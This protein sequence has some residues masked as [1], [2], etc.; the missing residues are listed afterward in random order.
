MSSRQPIKPAV[1]EAPDKPSGGAGD[2]G[3]SQHQGRELQ[4]VN[5]RLVEESELLRLALAETDSLRQ[6]EATVLRERTILFDSLKVLSNARSSSDALHALLASLGAIYQACPVCLLVTIDNETRVYASADENHLDLSVPLVS[7]AL[8]QSRRMASLQPLG[9]SATLPEVFQCLHSLVMVPLPLESVSQQCALLLGAR[10]SGHFS[11]SDLRVVER[12][13]ALAQPILTGLHEAEERERLQ[14]EL[15]IAQR[16]EMIGQVAAGLAHDFNNLLAAIGGNASLISS[17]VQ[18]GSAAATGAGRIQAAVDQAGGLVRRLLA[19]GARQP[20]R[21]LIDLGVPVRQAADLLQANLHPPL[22]LDVRLSDDTLKVL[23]DPTDIMQ[24]LLN[25]GINARDA[26]QGGEGNIT[27]SLGVASEDDLAGECLIGQPD[28]GRRYM[29]LGVKDQG[30]GI[31]HDKLDL[32]FKRYVTTKGNQG[33]GLGLAIVASIVTANQAALKVIS[34]PDQGCHFLIL[35][36]EEAAEEKTHRP[37]P[38]ALTGNLTGCSVLVVDD[39]Q[40]VLSVITEM[41]EEAGA[42]VAPTDAP[43]DVVEALR[44]DPGAW[45]MVITDYDMP[46]MSGDELAHQVRQ[47]APGL[48]VLLITALATIRPLSG[49]IFD[50]CIEKPVNKERLIGTVECLLATENKGLH[51]CEF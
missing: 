44:D 28:P 46:D 19:L 4:R 17:D 37:S 2:A 9:A 15:Q 49:N 22:T 5:Q 11:A 6:R 32:L 41:L 34:T 35:W 7:G 27:L 30:P 8:C 42:E 50:A 40:A 25:L 48:P 24:L 39:Q 18:A 36:P 10:E 29:A 47:Q 21:S 3:R 38:T 45:D 20:E 13:A 51:Q 23:A 1:Y 26:M 33:S 31:A 16:R 12:I 43:A 14:H